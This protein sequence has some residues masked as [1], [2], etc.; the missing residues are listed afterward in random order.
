MKIKFIF[1][2]VITLLLFIIFVVEGCDYK[3]RSSQQTNEK[4]Y[5]IMLSL[6]GFR[7]DYPVH[8][9]TPV[10][11]SLKHVGVFAELKP[12]F[13]SKT[14]PNHYSIATGLYPDHHG[15][16]LNRFYA[17]DLKRYYSISDRKSVGNGVFYGGEPIWVTAHKQGVENATLFW[18]GSEAAIKGIRPDK[19]Y[20]YDETL[21]F[22]SRIDSVK[23]WLSLPASQRPHLI[24]WYYHE[25]DKS[26][27]HYGPNGEKTKAMVE[28]LD[29]WLGIFFTEMRQLPQFNK[30]NFIITS[31]HGMATITKEKS[32]FLS[33]LIDTSDL[34]MINGGN[35]VFNL[36]VKK[37]KLQK[38]YNLLKANKH[39][40][41]WKHDSLPER[42][43]YGTNIR[44][45]DLTLVADTGWSIYLSPPHHFGNGT[46]GYDNDW[47]AMHAI[48]YAAGP[49]FKKN[50][51]QPVF[52]NVNIY[53]LI[54][55]ILKLKPAKNDGNLNIVKEML[56]ENV[57][58]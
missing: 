51:R 10:L 11:D 33:A 58:K 45:L 19:W 25:P 7:W 15:I 4:P 57:K 23:T 37:G 43:H 55:H 29:K 50:Y 2:Q 42:L 53:P 28:Q 44:T 40:K 34:R 17:P 16:V 21:P 39:L 14:F 1:W 30:L 38:V 52:E 24:L 41:V 49:A 35:P 48:F 47:R 27:H 13:P 56:N 22:I 18:V 26:G 8:C 54:A 5:V 20:V 32:L 36:K 12:C 9:N 46:H 6:D 3:A 31:D